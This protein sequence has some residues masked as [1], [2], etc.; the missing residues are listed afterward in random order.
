[1][2]TPFTGEWTFSNVHDYCAKLKQS[3]EINSFHVSH[4]ND[5]GRLIHVESDDGW[6]PEPLFEEFPDE[7]YDLI[8]N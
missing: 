6:N 1:M 5:R 2:K 3:G 7:A 8:P 4:D